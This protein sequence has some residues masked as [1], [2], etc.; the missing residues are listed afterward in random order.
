MKEESL[1]DFNKKLEA[2]HSHDPFYQAAQEIILAKRVK[3]DEV[4]DLLQTVPFADQLTPDG[5]RVVYSRLASA[6]QIFLSV[7]L[8][9]LS[10]LQDQ[11]PKPHLS[12]IDKAANLPHFFLAGAKLLSKETGWS[13]RELS[14]AVATMSLITDLFLYQKLAKTKNEKSKLKTDITY[15]ATVHELLV[16]AKTGSF[17]AA[18]FPEQIQQEHLYPQG[19]LLFGKEAEVERA[20][21]RFLFEGYGISTSSITSPTSGEKRKVVIIKRDKG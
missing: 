5:R 12:F 9:F 8:L 17:L 11:F 14:I 2:D 1:A 21:A 4:L 20:E 10:S 19:L 3:T 15:L 18:G 7:Q 16:G 13:E 6:D